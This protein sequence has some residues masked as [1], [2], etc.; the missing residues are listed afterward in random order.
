MRF[1]AFV[2]AM[3]AYVSLSAGC[4]F[5]DKVGNYVT[6]ATLAAATSKIDE[7][8]S[9]RGTSIAELKAAFFTDKEGRISSEVLLSNVKDVAKAV[10]VDRM[11]SVVA[12]HVG[13]AKEDVQRE[14]DTLRSRMDADGNGKITK[15]E[16]SLTVKQELAGA[17]KEIKDD[18]LATG[19]QMASDLIRGRIDEVR[20]EFAQWKED[21]KGKLAA[22]WEKI[23]YI[24]GVLVTSYLGKQVVSQRGKAKMDSR[25]ALLEKMTGIDLNANGVVGNGGEKATEDA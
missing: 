23:I 16:V 19:K 8:L 3:L 6:E 11:D 1:S 17:V 10:V 21:T 15:E 4:A 12:D 20:S 7:K 22:V 14:M 18:T 9:E 25:L 2:F 13:K 24:V 5:K